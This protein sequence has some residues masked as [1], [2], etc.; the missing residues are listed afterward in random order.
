MSEYTEGYSVAQLIGVHWMH[1][2]HGGMT[3]DAAR[4]IVCDSG[5]RGETLADD[6][7]PRP[8]TRWEALLTNHWFAKLNRDKIPN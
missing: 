6:P 3:A 2:E 7:P 4:S 8:T 1:R 5:F